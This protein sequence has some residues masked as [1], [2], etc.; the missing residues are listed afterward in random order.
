M[1]TSENAAPSRHANVPDE[2]HAIAK[3]NQRATDDRGRAAELKVHCAFQSNER[4]ANDE[5]SN[6]AGMTNPNDKG[7]VQRSFVIYFN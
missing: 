5:M 3:S 4:I 2:R 6:E 1:L 7:D